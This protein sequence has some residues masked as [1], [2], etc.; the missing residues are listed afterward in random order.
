MR[1]YKV[2]YFLITDNMNFTFSLI[3]YPATVKE[4]TNV[5][6]VMLVMNSQNITPDH[7]SFC[8]IHEKSVMKKNLLRF[9]SSGKN[10]I[11]F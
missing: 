9:V 10:K 7:Y 8:R 1:N 11:D 4:I 3:G 2:I 6:N 5:L